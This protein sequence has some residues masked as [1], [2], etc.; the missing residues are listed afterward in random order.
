[1][2]TADEI[3]TLFRSVVAAVVLFNDQVSQSTGIGASESQMLHLLELRGPMT[4][5]QLAEQTG[6]S[7]GTVTGVLDRLEQAGFAARE[8]HPTDRR[9]VIVTPNLERLAQTLAPLYT[10]QSATLQKAVAG[11][12][13]IEREAVVKFLTLLLADVPPTPPRS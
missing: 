11:L 3:S 1:M 9:K 5:S 12:S 7:T 13:P 6:L 4:P 8:R 10:E 2:S